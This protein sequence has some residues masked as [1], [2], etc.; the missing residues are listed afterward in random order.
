[1][2][3]FTDKRG[4]PLEVGQYIVYGKSDRDNPLN[5]GIIVDI[6]EWYIEVRGDGNVKTGKLKASH[7]GPYQSRIIVLPDEYA[8]IDKLKRL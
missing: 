2:T 7:W 6:T 5:T 4:T 3:E 8:V 1:M